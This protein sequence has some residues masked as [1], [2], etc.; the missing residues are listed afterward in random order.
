MINQ[1]IQPC[2]CSVCLCTCVQGVRQY[3]TNDPFILLHLGFLVNQIFIT[4]LLAFALE[5][6]ANNN[7]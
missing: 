1:P 3:H 7:L 4:I 2:V 5:R 6:Q